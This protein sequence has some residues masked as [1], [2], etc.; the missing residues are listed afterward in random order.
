MDP[1]VR[2]HRD[3]FTSPARDQ[4]RP[5]RAHSLDSMALLGLGLAWHASVTPEKYLQ[6]AFGSTPSVTNR[7]IRIGRMLLRDALRRM[8]GVPP[9]WSTFSEQRALVRGVEGTM[10]KAPIPGEQ[11]IFSPHLCG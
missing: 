8:P 3:G 6:M 11:H 9:S 5:G 7:D 2:A 10:G 1:A 4:M